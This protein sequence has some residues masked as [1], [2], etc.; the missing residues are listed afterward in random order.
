[1]NNALYFSNL[2]M[3]FFH[4]WPVASSHGTLLNTYQPCPQ[5]HGQGH[6]LTLIKFTMTMTHK[7]GC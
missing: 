7:G 5:G 2:S 3:D 4:I 6:L 1:M